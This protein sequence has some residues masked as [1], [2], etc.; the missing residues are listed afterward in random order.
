MIHFNSSGKNKLTRCILSILVLQN[1]YLHPSF[2]SLKLINYLLVMEKAFWARN[3]FIW[4]TR[5]LLLCTSGFNHCRISSTAKFISNVRRHIFNNIYG[6]KNSCVKAPFSSFTDCLQVLRVR[7]ACFTDAVKWPAIQATQAAM[8]QAAPS[9][10]LTD[11]FWEKKAFILRKRSKFWALSTQM[12]FLNSSSVL[13]QTIPRQIRKRLCH[14]NWF[15]F[16]FM[17]KFSPLVR[18][19]TSDASL[20]SLQP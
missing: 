13:L 6:Q 1:V 14:F 4:F 8:K 16:I 12:I 9:A 5:T 2:H 10:V 19:A 20:Q 3:S 18:P 11:S 17:R 7:A 15:L